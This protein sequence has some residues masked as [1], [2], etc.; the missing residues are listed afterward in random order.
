MQSS[1]NRSES[2]RTTTRPSPCAVATIT[3]RLGT[4]AVAW[5]RASTAAPFVAEMVVA[6]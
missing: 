6:R 4:D 1:P 3:G 2:A 5:V